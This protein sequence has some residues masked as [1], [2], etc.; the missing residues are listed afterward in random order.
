MIKGTRTEKCGFFLFPS[1]GGVPVGR[2]A[3]DCRAS[4]AH[5]G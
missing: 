5:E 4:L 3:K 1:L 2:G